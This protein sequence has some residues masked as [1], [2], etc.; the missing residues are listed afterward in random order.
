MIE[1]ATSCLKRGM[2]HDLV[3]RGGTIVDGTGAPG[4]TGD[5][6]ID[7]DRLTQVGG[8]AGTGKREIDAA[9]LAVRREGL[10]C[11]Q[12]ERTEEEP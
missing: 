9:G 3:I 10:G 2:A 1:R 6:A 12:E 4:R 7:G 11:Q 8:K 5:V